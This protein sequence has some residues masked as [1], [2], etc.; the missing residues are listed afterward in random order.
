MK[1]KAMKDN[2][3]WD[4]SGEPDAEIQELEEILGSLRYQPRPLEIPSH[5]Q[6]GY[7]RRFFPA[8]ALAAAIALFAVLIV[9]WFSFNRRPAPVFQANNNSQIEQPGQVAQPVQFDQPVKETLPP[10]N[11]PA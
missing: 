9:A 10:P 3:L 4:R 5:L 2:F 6:I 7:H 11:N 8:M 1:E